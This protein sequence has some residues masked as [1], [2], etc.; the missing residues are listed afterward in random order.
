MAPAGV[1]ASDAGVEEP[2]PQTSCGGR[3]R[4]MALRGQGLVR[5]GGWAIVCPFCFLDSW[6]FVSCLPGPYWSEGRSIWAVAGFKEVLSLHFPAGPRVRV[7]NPKP[8]LLL[9]VQADNGAAPLGLASPGP[10]QRRSL[11]SCSTGWDRKE[12]VFAVSGHTIGCDLDQ[13]VSISIRE[14][15]SAPTPAGSQ[16]QPRG[17]I[18]VPSLRT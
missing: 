17:S 13:S 18:I 15:L 7:E 5:A 2:G 14:Y 8:S 10:S 1:Q 3:W 12:P 9:Q 4:G 16:E 11:A 6:V